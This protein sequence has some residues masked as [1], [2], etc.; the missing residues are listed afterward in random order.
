MGFSKFWEKFW[1]KKTVDEYE[2]G[3]Q[4]GEKV[5]GKNKKVK[6]KKLTIEDFD[7]PKKT[8]AKKSKPITY[9]F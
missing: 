4:E 6:E 8:K 9:N 7:K 2:K 1:G 5:F 3:L